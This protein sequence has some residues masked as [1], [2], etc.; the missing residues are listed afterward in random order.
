MKK[1]L[2]VIGLGLSLLGCRNDCDEAKDHW[3]DCMDREDQVP[4]MSDDECS[5][6]NECIANCVK[7]A[8]CLELQ[9]FADPSGTWAQCTSKC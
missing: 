7:D 4:G 3:E 9:R 6:K 1:L 2:V 8:D 5:G